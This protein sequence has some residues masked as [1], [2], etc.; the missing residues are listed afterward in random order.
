M[1]ALLFSHI[2]I[3]N[4]I[5]MFF[6]APSTV[7]VACYSR[8]IKES[9]LGTFVTFATLAAAFIPIFLLRAHLQRVSG[10]SWGKLQTSQMQI[11]SIIC[12]VSGIAS[13]FAAYGVKAYLEQ[14]DH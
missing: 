11:W 9:G 2:P 4:A 7:I 14:R 8:Y 13:M 6:F 12:F 1:N 5:L 10:G 3:G